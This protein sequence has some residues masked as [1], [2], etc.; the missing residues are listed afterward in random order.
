[1]SKST[2]SDIVT[3]HPKERLIKVRSSAVRPDGTLVLDAVKDIYS[4]WKRWAASEEGIVFG[5]LVKAKGGIVLPSG[6]RTETHVILQEGWKIQCPN[7]TQ[8][9][10]LYGNLHSSDADDPITTRPDG[11]KVVVSHRRRKD[12]VRNKAI[13]VVSLAFII[14][15]I[16]LLGLWIYCEPTEVEPY[17]TLAV[18]LFTLMQF[19]GQGAR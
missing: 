16:A 9:V 5:E 1:M 6:F 12:S 11:H 17:A 10:E 14:F 19:L 18:V 15:G 13:Y 8:T 4:A 2:P 3:F 7:E